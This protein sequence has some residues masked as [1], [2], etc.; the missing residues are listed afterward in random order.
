MSNEKK[1]N[2]SPEKFVQPE[3]D[4]LSDA[5]L[6]SVSGGSTAIGCASTGSGL[7]DKTLCCVKQ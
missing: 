6:T 3:P 4:Q 1:T 2:P 5:E 7:D